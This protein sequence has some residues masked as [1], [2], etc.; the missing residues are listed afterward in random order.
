[1]NP[2]LD[3]IIAALGRIAR[4]CAAPVLDALIEWR[5]PKQREADVELA[6]LRTCVG[7]RTHSGGAGPCEAHGHP[8]S[9]VGGDRDYLERTRR[10]AS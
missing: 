5:A 8:R 4:F 2:Q 6:K 7:V 3:Q 9:P 10:T 1:M